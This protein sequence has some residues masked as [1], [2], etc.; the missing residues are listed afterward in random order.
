MV[1]IIELVIAFVGTYFIVRLVRTTGSF[2]KD[3][4]NKEIEKLHR[5]LFEL[6]AADK[7][8]TIL[9]LELQIGLKD[10]LRPTEEQLKNIT[11]IFNQPKE[12]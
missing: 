11:N 2:A 1:E 5:F 7:V 4:T 12:M 3:R 10:C 9:P 6:E 8:F